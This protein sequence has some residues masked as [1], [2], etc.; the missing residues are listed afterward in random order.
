MGKG[1]LGGAA[2][3]S[4]VSAQ[5]KSGIRKGHSSAGLEKDPWRFLAISFVFLKLWSLAIFSDSGAGIS[6]MVP[7]S[8]LG[9]GDS[10]LFKVLWHL[11]EQ[12]KL[13]EREIIYVKLIVDII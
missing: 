8:N 12:S 9:D 4:Q 1:K 6:W 7:H 5:H 10:A 13:P 11:W 2:C 3:S